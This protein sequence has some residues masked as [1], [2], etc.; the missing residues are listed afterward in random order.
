MDHALNNLASQ[1][2]TLAQW[3]F[4]AIWIACGFYALRQKRVVAGACLL[5]SGFSALLFSYL[6]VLS[7]WFT[8]GWATDAPLNVAFSYKPVGYLAANLLPAIG[9][10]ALVIALIALVRQ[11]D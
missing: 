3:L 8:D 9:N 4:P 2:A 11:R 7:N 6:F 5:L 1:W 10:I